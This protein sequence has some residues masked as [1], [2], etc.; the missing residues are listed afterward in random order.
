[1]LDSCP[2]PLVCI[3]QTAVYLEKIQSLSFEM[4]PRY[5]HNDITVLITGNPNKEINVAIRSA[6]K[7]SA[8]AAQICGIEILSRWWPTTTEHDPLISAALPKVCVEKGKARSGRGRNC[9]IIWRTMASDRF[10]CAKE[11]DVILI[12]V[13]L[14]TLLH[15]NIMNTGFCKTSA[16]CIHSKC[17]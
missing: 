15:R 7:I 4:R 13:G 3:Q 1:M 9:W 14:V 17:S 12:L 8:P 16:S 6:T 11:T 10:I 5:H 2:E